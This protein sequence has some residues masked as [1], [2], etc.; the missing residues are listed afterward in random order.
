MSEFAHQ[1]GD[2]CD[3]RIVALARSLLA[4]VFGLSLAKACGVRL[5]FR[6]PPVLWLRSGAGSL[7]LLCTFFALTRLR[8][9]EVLT[10][11]NT[12]PIW[13]A[14]LSWPIL[15]VRPSLTVWFAACCGV[16]GIFLIQQ[17][18]YD[19]VPGI[20]FAVPLA[21]LAAFTSAVAMLGLH[22]LKGLDPL[23]IVVHFSGVATLAVLV[24]WA[25]GDFPDLKPLLQTNHLAFLLGI[26]VTAVLGQMCLTRAF[27]SGQP[28][29]VSIVGLTQI[30]FAMGLDLAFGGKPFDATTLAGIGL[31]LAPTAL[32]MAGKTE[33]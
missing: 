13:V 33:T 29:R 18:H 6:D 28:A 20:Q 12:F 11:T 23:A 25:I 5:V 4:F 10:L 14:I 32:V 7:S 24:T 19:E 22:R 15:R 26:G 30:V 17:P 9:S 1:L 21:L 3:W 27:T 2:H 8:T 16:L 31:V